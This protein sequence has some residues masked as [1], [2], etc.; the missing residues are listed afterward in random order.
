MNV[1]FKFKSQVTIILLLLVAGVTPTKIFGQN[2]T[3]LGSGNNWSD[4]NNWSGLIVAPGPLVFVGTNKTS[5][6]NDFA[7]NTAYN[8]SFGAGDAFTLSGNTLQLGGS[9]LFGSFDGAISVNAVPSSGIHTINL[10]GLSLFAQ[11][12]LSSVSG[13]SLQI[14]SPI[15][16]ASTLTKS[17]AGTVILAGNNAFTNTTTISAGTLNIQHAN[18]LG[19]TA[20]STSVT[21]GA[22]L[23]I[24]GGITTAAEGLTLNGNGVGSGG[25]LQNVSGNNTYSGAI[26]LGS[27]SRINS[28]LGTLTLDVASGNAISGTN[29][30]TFGGSG[31]IVVA[32][33]IATGTGTLT[34]DGSGTLTLTAANTYSGST[35]IN[36]GSLQLGNGSTTGSL[37]VASSISLGALTAGTL[38]INRSNTVT[39]GTDFSGNAITGLGGITQAGSGTT[40][41]NTSNSYSGTT[42]VSSGTLNIQ[43]GNAL[44]N[45]TGGTIVASGA[46]LSIQGG[47]TTAAENLTLSGNGVSSGGA[48]QN[49]SGNNTFAGAITLAADARINSAS[50]TL[51]LDVASGNAISG[52]NTNVTFGGSGDI[53]VADAISTGNGTLTKDG[54]GKLT[55]TGANTY[56]GATTISGGSLQVGNNGTTGSIAGT[57]SV[58]IGSGSSLI[59]SRSGSVTQAD[60]L[61]GGVI[62]G[63]GALVKTGSGTLILTAA[64]SYTG[65]TTVSEGSLVINGNQSSATGS[66]IVANGATLSGSGTYGGATT[67][68]L[69]VNGTLTGTGT[70]TGN[71]IINGV[72]SPGNSPG[73]QTFNGNLSYS[74]GSSLN[75]ELIANT[76]TGRGT[77]FDG[78]NVGGGLTF[79]GAT[80]MNLLFNGA[81]STV[82]WNDSF[83][84]SN[85]SWLVYDVAGTT[86]GFGLFSINGTTW[87]DA[88][89][90]SL[91]SIRSGANFTLDQS[92]DDVILRFDSGASSVPEPGSLALMSVVGLFGGGRLA[93]RYL[94]RRKN[95]ETNS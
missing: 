27:A 38:T 70:I 77:N 25:A 44:G 21:S 14:N 80:S 15:S 30:V 50:G 40:E 10:D 83:W 52:T 8:I 64:N 75:W 90:N 73:L 54:S 11:T 65:G 32:D 43:N 7:N 57:S 59:V 51:T 45:T 29:N 4:P 39:Q 41:L 87:L 1:D 76:S 3:G 62:S 74:T 19:T 35:T 60:V 12:T 79:S 61:G 49:V 91:T 6:V 24:Q 86:T 72:H 9:G 33:A 95:P 67:D 56:S 88:F 18:A 5:T 13:S 22:T 20:G 85:R 92:G 71:T 94:R 93:Q 58:S 68:T 26:T 48:L 2:W 16:G 66:I 55:L 34:K 28:D 81:G 89:N 53:V 69:T 84:A 31:N 82:N 78:I 63:Q 37:N 46:T 47:I 17:G 36:Q 23:A 42:T